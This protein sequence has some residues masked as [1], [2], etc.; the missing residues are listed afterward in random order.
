MTDLIE[1]NHESRLSVFSLS[2]SLACQLNMRLESL[3]PVFCDCL[4]R[5]YFAETE[6]LLLKLL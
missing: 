1:K 4:D 2:L 3:D 5:I 6:N